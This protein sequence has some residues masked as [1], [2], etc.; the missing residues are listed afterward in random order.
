MPC[1][2]DMRS[3]SREPIANCTAGHAC[4]GGGWQATAALLK[5]CCDPE[6]AQQRRLPWLRAAPAQ[7][8]RRLDLQHKPKQLSVQVVTMH[9]KYKTVQAGCAKSKQTD[10][11]AMLPVTSK[12]ETLQAGCCINRQT[13][14]Q[15]RYHTADRLVTVLR[16][17]SLYS[18]TTTAAY[19]GLEALPH[20]QR[21]QQRLATVQR[22]RAAPA[23]Q[24][25]RGAAGPPWGARGRPPPLSRRCLGQR[26]SSWRLSARHSCMLQLRWRL[27][28]A[29]LQ[30]H[31]LWD[32]DPGAKGEQRRREGRRSLAVCSVGAACLEACSCACG[33]KRERCSCSW[34]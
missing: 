14:L 24:E 9:E 13:G 27:A 32:A 29:E 34:N 19:L 3:C 2:T 18:R 17:Q 28:G 21:Q 5:L 4:L 6:A 33:C 7:Q 30:G 15:V 1:T 23:G 22:Q 8:L 25:L 11:Q 16:D 26:L 31:E 12:C 10:L 20:V